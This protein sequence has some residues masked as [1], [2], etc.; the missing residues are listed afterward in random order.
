MRSF[1][2]ALYELFIAVY[3]NLPLSYPTHI[4]GTIISIFYDK[5]HLS[6]ILV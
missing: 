1:R 2:I 5:V 6:Q 3:Q 4:V